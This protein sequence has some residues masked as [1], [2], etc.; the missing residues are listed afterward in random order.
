MSHSVCGFLLRWQ[1]LQPGV[2]GLSSCPNKLPDIRGPQ[3]LSVPLFSHSLEGSE[4]GEGMG[5]EFMLMPILSAAFQ[6]PE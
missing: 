2:L 5:T 6:G 1:C 3:S 4:E